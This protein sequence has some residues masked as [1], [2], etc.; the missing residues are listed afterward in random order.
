MVKESWFD[1]WWK[2]GCLISLLVPYCT[3]AE[4]K[5]GIKYTCCASKL[6]Y[7]VEEH[8]LP[9]S[10]PGDCKYVSVWESSDC[11]NEQKTLVCLNQGG[12]VCLCFE[13]MCVASCKRMCGVSWTME[14]WITKGYANKEDGLQ[15]MMKWCFMIICWDAHFS[16]NKIQISCALIA[17][18]PVKKCS[19]PSVY[20]MVC[21]TLVTGSTLSSNLP[22]R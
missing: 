5:H 21:T 9:P 12:V 7:Y 10:W 13:W 3:T 17:T 6:Y 19:H 14:Q 4:K 18:C 2:E 16:I 11:R 20:C 22:F 1:V 8:F 15:V